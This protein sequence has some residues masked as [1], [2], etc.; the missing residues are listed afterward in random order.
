MY[1]TLPSICTS[2]T[3]SEVSLPESDSGR[4]SEATSDHMQQHSV[5]HHRVRG[6]HVCGTNLDSMGATGNAPY[7]FA[8]HTPPASSPTLL[9]VS[10]PPKISTTTSSTP[11]IAPTALALLLA[12]SPTALLPTL[13]PKAPIC[14]TLHIASDT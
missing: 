6:L 13:L 1:P 10:M 11:S 4:T 2:P 3:T 14:T 5:R 8:S 7:A 9:S 12:P